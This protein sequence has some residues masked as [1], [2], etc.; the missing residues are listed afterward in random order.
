MPYRSNLTQNVE[1]ISLLRISKCIIF[2]QPPY[3][4]LLRYYEKF[5]TFGSVLM[6]TIQTTFQNVEVYYFMQPPYINFLKY[7]EKHFTV[8][9]VMMSRIQNTF[10]NV[11]V[12]YFY[13]TAIY[14]FSKILWKIHY[15]WMRHDEKNSDHFQKCR[16]L[17][18]S[19]SRHILIFKNFM[20]NPLPLE[21]SWWAKFRTLFRM[22]KF[23]IFMQ[24][25]YI[26]LLR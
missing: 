11:E 25:P 12:Y 22:S 20:K 14:C 6:S 26:N 24:P 21:A 17:L 5:F 7:Y 3:S 13:S 15:R 18:F 16:S 23:I 1:F 2:M 8:G 9:S 19:C 4:N 10:Q